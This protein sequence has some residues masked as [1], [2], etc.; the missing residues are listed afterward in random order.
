MPT[1]FRHRG[2]RFFFY[3]NEGTRGLHWEGLDED[4][5]VVGL[6]RGRG[7]QAGPRKGKAA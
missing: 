3:A 5:S 1:V 6:L 4:V 2:F 7:D